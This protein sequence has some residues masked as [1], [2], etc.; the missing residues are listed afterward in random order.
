MKRQNEQRTNAEGMRMSFFYG[1]SSFTI[2]S[3]Y[4]NSITYKVSET[5]FLL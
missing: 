5:V 1:D 2:S 4:L 3:L